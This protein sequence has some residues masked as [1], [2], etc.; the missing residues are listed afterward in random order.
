MRLPDTINRKKDLPDIQSRILQYTPGANKSF[1]VPKEE[2][3]SQYVAR[4]ALSVMQIDTSGVQAECDFL[5]HCKDKPGEI[6]EPAWYAMIGVVSWLENGEKLCHDYSSGHPGYSE[7][8][9]QMKIHQAQRMTGPR[10]CQSIDSLWGKCSGCKHFGNIKTPLQIMS[11]NFIKTET[12]GFRRLVLG[13]DGNL[14]PGPIE[15]GDVLKAFVR[16]YKYKAQALSA[17]ARIP[18]FWTYIDNL[19]QPFPRLLVEDWLEKVCKGDIRASEVSE[20]IAKLGRNNVCET[21]FFERS[22]TLYKQFENCVLSIETGEMLAHSPE[23]GINTSIPHHYDKT[24]TCPRWDQFLDEIC[25]GDEGKIRLLNEFAGY[26]LFSPDNW[27]QKTLILIGNGANGKSVY[28]EIMAKLVGKNNYSAVPIH[29]LDHEYNVAALE[30][31]LLNVS[32]ETSFRALRD[33]SNF[34]DMVAGGEVIGRN[35]YE[36]PRPIKI[37]AKFILACNEPPETNDSTEGFGRRPIIIELNRMF[38]PDTPGYDPLLSR[39]LEAEL[40]G[41]INRVQ[42]CYQDLKARGRFD[43]TEEILASKAAFI[44]GGNYVDEFVHQTL[45]AGSSEDF[46]KSGDL[47]DLAKEFC[48]AQNI[49]DK[50]IHS[51]VIARVIRTKF[52]IRTTVLRKVAGKVVRVWEGIKIKDYTEV[53]NGF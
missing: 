48:F 40:P 49:D 47:I 39:K 28:L 42:A 32:G 10:T 45:E 27:L 2:D 21:D 25:E 20:A 1:L 38:T 13:K 26:I 22:H 31:K 9:T 37:R 44:R 14:R 24:K 23:Y 19:W 46:V 3:S 11:D 7:H 50:R 6:K 33:S 43:E 17:D 29:K 16:D 12:T 36:S 15:Y 8:E 5:A 30:N 35:P 52:G 53:G 18:R 4:A 41:I 34:K 51:R